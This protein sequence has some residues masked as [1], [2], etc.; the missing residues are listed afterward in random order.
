LRTF[1]E[2]V[3]MDLD[4]SGL[5]LKNKKNFKESC[6]KQGGKASEERNGGEL[7]LSCEKENKVLGIPLNG[8]KVTV[9]NKSN[10]SEG[11]ADE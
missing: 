2:V 8:L 3:K 6:E 9:I 7:L 1:V 4:F 11:E 5:N 10:E